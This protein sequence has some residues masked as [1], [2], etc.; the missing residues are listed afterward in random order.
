ML[1][2]QQYVCSAQR[3]FFPLLSDALGILRK[4]PPCKVL[5]E[6]VCLHWGLHAQVV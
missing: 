6:P 4:V 2:V 5:S 3:P 1:F